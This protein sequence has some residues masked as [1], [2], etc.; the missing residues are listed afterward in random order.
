MGALGGA[1]PSLLDANRR[2]RDVLRAK[3][4][5]VDYLEVPGGEHSPESWRARLPVGLAALAPA[6]P[7]APAR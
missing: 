7:A 4:Y 6:A 1:A 2:L 5:A 3:R